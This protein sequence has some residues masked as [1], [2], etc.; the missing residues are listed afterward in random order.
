MYDRGA[1]DVKISIIPDDGRYLISVNNVP[2]TVVADLQLQKWENGVQYNFPAPEGDYYICWWIE[3][4]VG[5]YLMIRPDT[6]SDCYDVAGGNPVVD[7]PDS[8]LNDYVDVLPRLNLPSID[9]FFELEPIL[10]G[11]FSPIFYGGAGRMYTNTSLYDYSGQE[12][13]DQLPLG[14]FE[15][16]LGLFSSGEK[17]Y[18]DGR[19]ELDTN[20]LDSPIPDGGGGKSM[21]GTFCSNVPKNF[22]NC[23]CRSLVL[24]SGESA[25]N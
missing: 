19:I 13:C 4:K 14:D 22:L 20:T 8:I 9:D 3:E 24:L 10:Y 1:E 16:L 21:T 18:Y 5:G 7:L 6:D 15:N 2:R 23:K 25:Y 12:Q 11:Y 17:A